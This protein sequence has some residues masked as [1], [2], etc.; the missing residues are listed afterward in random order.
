MATSPPRTNTTR[1]TQ[2]PAPSLATDGK[3]GHVHVGRAK[4]ACWHLF[5]AVRRSRAFVCGLSLRIA[6]SGP[7]CSNTAKPT[8]RDESSHVKAAQTGEIDASPEIHC[9]VS[10]SS[11]LHVAI[12]EPRRFRGNP[13]KRRT[14]SFPN[15]N[16]NNP[17]TVASSVFEAIIIPTARPPLRRWKDARTTH[18]WLDISALITPA[19][20]PSDHV[21]SSLITNVFCGLANAIDRT[22]LSGGRFSKR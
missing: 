8:K 20:F 11:A 5:V 9:R 2:L 15:I 12:A 17:E 19:S 10:V 7:S 16:R 1:D 6:E 21:R 4:W 13:T 22:P 18:A 14:R 3:A